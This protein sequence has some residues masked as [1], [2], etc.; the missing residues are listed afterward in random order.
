MWVIADN[1]RVGAA[2]NAVRILLKHKE[3][4]WSLK[5]YIIGGVYIEKKG[6]D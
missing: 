3:L 4:N 6:S 1:I 5:D 2:T